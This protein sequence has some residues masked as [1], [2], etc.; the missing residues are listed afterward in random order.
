MK[1]A[2]PRNI[3]GTLVALLLSVVTP[4]AIADT[5]PYLRI[6]PGDSRA[7][8]ASLLGEPVESRDLSEGERH[9]IQSAL[10]KTDNKDAVE[11]KIWKQSERLYYLVGFNSR[12]KVAAK[13]RLLALVGAK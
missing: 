13:H 5:D 8:V 1:H 11:F 2:A 4:G 3:L 12:G 9:T 10:E 6:A 7:K